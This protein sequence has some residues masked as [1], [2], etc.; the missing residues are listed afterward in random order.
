MEDRR[1]E[2]KKEEGA[3]TSLFHQLMA[4]RTDVDEDTRIVL[5]RLIVIAR[6]PRHLADRTELGAHYEKLNFQLSKQFI[7][8]QMT[9]LL[10]I[11]PSCLLHVIESSRDV[12]LSF[13]RDLKDM[14]QQPDGAVLEAPRVVFMAHNP[15]SRLFQQWSYKCLMLLTEVLDADQGAEDSG[16]KRLE[17]E[18]ESTE[19]LVCTVL[20]ALQLLGEHLQIS[21]K[22]LPGLMLEERPHLIVSQDVLNK[23]L[24]RDDLQTPQQ[25]L[26]MYNSPLNIS[27]DF[28]RVR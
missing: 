17:E 7:W 15:Q 14:Q 6:L 16:V 28:G 10:L 2:K 13:L 5:Q 26:Q 4:Q 9:G 12:L 27:M 23:L 11:Y 8:D 21:K 25:H 3:G 19:S 1:A 20:S 22:A 18:E 24:T